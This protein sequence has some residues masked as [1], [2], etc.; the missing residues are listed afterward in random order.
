MIFRDAGGLVRIS[1][2]QA[3]LIDGLLGFQRAPQHTVA[4]GPLLGSRN[5]LD[6]S[7]HKALVW[8]ARGVSELSH[9]LFC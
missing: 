8:G 9:G 2:P 1:D 4:A 5:V 7:E 3:M 6:P